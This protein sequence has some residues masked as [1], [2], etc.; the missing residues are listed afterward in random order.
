M[1]IESG[2]PCLVTGAS[3]GIGRA[4]ALELARRG[5]RVGLLARSEDAL[6]ELA[7]E[8]AE[9]GGEGLAVAADVRS[10]EQVEQAIARLVEAFGGLRLVV[11]NA[12]LGRYAAVA[13]QPAEH[14]D[15]TIGI[16]YVG[17]TRTI[18]HALPHL[19]AAT[20]SHVVGLTSSAGLI[21][22]RM[23]SAY[24]ASK[25]ASNAYLATLRLEVLERGVGVS[26]ICPGIVETPFIAKADLDPS[27]DL[28]RLA[29]IFV[30]HLEVDEVARATVRAIEGNKRQVVMPWMMRFFAWTRRMAPGFGDWLNRV[31]G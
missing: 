28:P 17:L 31:T 22:H 6:Q 26:W 9:V 29:R 15:T 11:A 3:S 23:G 13:E 21:P 25:A 10:E 20:P 4:I 7:A 30:R 16:N 8:L 1:K 27:Q 2:T 24:C 14:V 5:A 19:L 18:R 12:G